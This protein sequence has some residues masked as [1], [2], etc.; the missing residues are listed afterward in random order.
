[1]VGKKRT[2]ARGD[3]TEMR[4]STSFHLQS[5]HNYQ[6]SNR[7][8]ISGYGKKYH[9]TDISFTYVSRGICFWKMSVMCHQSVVMLYNPRFNKRT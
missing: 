4:L 9:G 3:Q 8:E 2:S 1:M 6:A 7:Q 5:S